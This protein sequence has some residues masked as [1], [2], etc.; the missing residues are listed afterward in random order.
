MARSF[1]VAVVD[2][3]P[4][5]ALTRIG[6]ARLLSR[7]FMRVLLAEA[8]VTELWEGSQRDRAF[9]IIR[10]P[11]VE[12]HR[13]RGDR[14]RGVPPGLSD[15]DRD[16]IALALATRDADVLVVDDRVARRHAKACG[17]EI[18]GTAGIIAWAKK[19][20]LVPS[21]RPLLEQLLGSGFR[22][23]GRLVDRVLLQLGE[24]PLGGEIPD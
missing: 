14:L 7:L 4:C 9:E 11:N 13:A 6:Q 3:S 24:E 23:D 8:V 18:I 12:I 19:R 17:L 1:R 22:L 5:I 15:A 21:A 16:T 10:A 20:G 2:T